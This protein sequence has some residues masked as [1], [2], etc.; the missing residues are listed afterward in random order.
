MD[1]E[2]SRN[3]FLFLAGNFPS[4][5]SARP[6][7]EIK[8]FRVH[9]AHSPDSENGLENTH[10]SLI[11][12]YF[13]EFVRISGSH[14]RASL[15]VPRY[16][17]VHIFDD[18]ELHMRARLFLM[19]LILS[20]TVL[21]AAAFERSFPDKAKRGTMSPAPYPTII[22]DGKERRLTAGGRIW[23]QDNLIQMPAT[24]RPGDYVVNYTES[25]QG[26]IDRIWILK[27]QEAER[28]APSQRQ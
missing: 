21:S 6:R 5:Q 15:F 18:T 27:P 25:L 13:P 3:P 17:H 20:S 8:Q 4:G 23:N 12:K 24:L 9:L 14:F 7:A 19:G 11:Y 22:V 26:E 28:P 10:K 2:S 1:Y 16:F